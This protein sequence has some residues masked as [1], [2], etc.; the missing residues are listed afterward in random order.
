MILD[1]KSRRRN[2]MPPLPQNVQST[3]KT[4]FLIWESPLGVFAYCQL[5]LEPD[6]LLIYV[7][8]MNF[9]LLVYCFYVHI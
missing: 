2:N 7:L 9:A 1:V 6:F 3:F 5:I 4:E 8:Q